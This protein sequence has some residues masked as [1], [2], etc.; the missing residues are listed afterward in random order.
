M[1]LMIRYCDG[2]H[3][4]PEIVE[5]SKMVDRG[6]EGRWIDFQ[7]ENDDVILRIL[8]ADVERVER[9]SDEGRANAVRSGEAVPDLSHILA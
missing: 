1:K 5:A 6:H 2:T 9:V 4:K 8:A 3:R 7:D